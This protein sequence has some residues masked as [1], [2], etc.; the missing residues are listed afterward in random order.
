MYMLYLSIY[1]LFKNV[2]QKVLL[3]FSTEVLHIYY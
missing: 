3:F 2:P 1:V